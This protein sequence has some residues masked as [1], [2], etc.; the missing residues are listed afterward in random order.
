MDV[1]RGRSGILGTT[2]DLDGRLVRRIRT[3]ADLQRHADG[4]GTNDRGDEDGHTRRIGQQGP[5]LTSI[6]QAANR[7]L[8]IEID[9]VEPLF[10]DDAG[11]GG[12]DGGVRSTDLA[13]TRRFL[14]R[15]YQKAQ[16]PAIAPGH[17]SGVDAFGADEAG[18]VLLHQQAKG[19][20]GML[21]HRSQRDGME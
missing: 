9:E 18:A 5:A 13:G 2:R 19:R 17:V 12:E 6:Q 14:R 8:E 10:L 7:A 21:L 1:H 11:R 3:A 4:H 16:R 20:I 15:R